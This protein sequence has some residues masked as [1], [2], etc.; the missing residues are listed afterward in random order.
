MVKKKDNLNFFFIFILIIFIGLF[1]FW[2]IDFNVYSFFSEESLRLM[3]GFLQEFFPPNFEISFLLKVAFASWETLAMSIVSTF[4]AVIFG[5]IVAIPASNSNKGFGAIFRYI[6][7]TLLN[8]LR[9]IPELVWAVFLIISAG[10]GPFAGTL[11]LM[12]HTT[13]VFGRLMA[14]AIENVDELPSKSLSDNG[15]NSLQVFSYAVLP[16]LAPQIISYALYR[17]EH[18]IRIATVLGVVGAGGL[19]QMLSYNLSLFMLDNSCTVI[20]SMILLVTV[21]DFSSSRI[22]GE[23]TKV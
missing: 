5:I 20:L 13:G 19:G 6:S 1:S 12:I 4:F 10:L 22:R 23:L 21:V 15:A 9:S 16:Q 7:R 2:K 3:L 8:L 17:W 11:A 18:N 14:D